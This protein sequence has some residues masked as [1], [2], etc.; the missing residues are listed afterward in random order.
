LK[1]EKLEFRFFTGPCNHLGISSVNV[2]NDPFVAVLYKNHPLAKNPH[3]TLEELSND[4]FILGS[5]DG[6][7]IYLEHL[8]RICE[9][10]GFTP[11]IVQQAFNSDGIFGLIACEMGITIH[12]GT[13]F[14]YRKEDLVVVPIKNVDETLPTLA[15]WKSENNSQVRQVFIDFLHKKFNENL[16]DTS[17]TAN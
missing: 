15:T 5:S 10:A 12:S 9:K 1:S 16:I 11:N 8:L 13:T 4:S 3:V 2:H 14:A 6:W 17:N 7:H